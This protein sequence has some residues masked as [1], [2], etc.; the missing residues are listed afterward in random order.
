MYYRLNVYQTVYAIN[1][2]YIYINRLIK[3]PFG[4]PDKSHKVAYLSVNII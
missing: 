2:T 4:W 3:F 1:Y